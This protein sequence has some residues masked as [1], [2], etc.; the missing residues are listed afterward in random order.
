MVTIS[1]NELQDL[2]NTCLDLKLVEVLPEIAYQDYH[3]PQAINVPL[4]D[5][6][7][8]RV[9]RLI[10]DRSNTIVVY[11]LNY[12]CHQSG[13]AAMCLLELGYQTVF[14]YEP[15]KIDWR[16]AQLPIEYGA[17]RIRY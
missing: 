4:S 7:N 11:S 8:E 6:F 2:L 12:E 3:L 14:D 16:A 1:R 15:G 5:F 17:S 13:Q 10:P 9:L